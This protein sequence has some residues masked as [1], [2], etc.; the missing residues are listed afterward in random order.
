[1]VS[2]KGL[3]SVRRGCRLCECCKALSSGLATMESRLLC[4]VLES[5]DMEGGLTRAVKA[6]I[7]VSSV[8]D[9][10]VVSHSL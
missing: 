10:S 3:I 7:R 2:R 6:G 4:R 9:C 8:V 1:M 5:F